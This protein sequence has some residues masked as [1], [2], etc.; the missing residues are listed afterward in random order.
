M[1]ECGRIALIS[2]SSSQRCA[3]FNSVYLYD[4]GKRLRAIVQSPP[5]RD[6]CTAKNFS[7]DGVCPAARRHSLEIA[8]C[9]AFA[10]YCSLPPRRRVWCE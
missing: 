1:E 4:L 10:A 6:E 3:G 7:N 2:E 9:G 5:A 8:L